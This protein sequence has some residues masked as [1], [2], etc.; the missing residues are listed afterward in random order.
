MLLLHSLLDL[1]I[2][3]SIFQTEETIKIKIKIKIKSNNRIQMVFCPLLQ[4][5]KQYA[6][7]QTLWHIPQGQ[8][9]IH[10]RAKLP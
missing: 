6:D 2:Y 9:F 8:L 7:E 10:W 4:K 1:T 3:N 5:L